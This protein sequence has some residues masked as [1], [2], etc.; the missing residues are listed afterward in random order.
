MPCSH[1]CQP[2]DFNSEETGF[3]CLG[4]LSPP[5]YLT[6]SVCGKCKTWQDVAMALPHGESHEEG[7]KC[8]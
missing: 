8:L 1:W 4:V 3:P 5:L 6:L 2:G 7:T